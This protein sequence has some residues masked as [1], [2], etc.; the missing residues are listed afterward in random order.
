MSS[1]VY[2]SIFGKFHVKQRGR[3]IHEWKSPPRLLKQSEKCPRIRLG[4]PWD[5][6]TNKQTKKKNQQRRS[7]SW[8]SL[9]WQPVIRKER[10]FKS[11]GIDLHCQ[12]FAQGGEGVGNEEALFNAKRVHIKSSQPLEGKGN[13]YPH[14]TGAS[15]VAA[16]VD[17]TTNRSLSP[18]S[19]GSESWQLDCG[20][21]W[22]N[23]LSP[24]C[25][26][27]S[28]GTYGEQLPW[29]R[30]HCGALKKPAWGGGTNWGREE[31][32]GKGEDRGLLSDPG[33]L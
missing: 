5:K 16:R 14:C 15:T 31:R 11:P 17:M 8:A 19:G 23:E 1:G 3:Y 12:F 9:A 4:Q 22:M 32:K 30:F 10:G 33:A 29:C 28:W 20:V 25:S 6:K 2:D 26:Q 21:N 13:Y 27:C 18:V 7:C 24:C